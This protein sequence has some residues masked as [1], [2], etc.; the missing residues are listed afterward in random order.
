MAIQTVINLSDRQK[1]LSSL[2]LSNLRSKIVARLNIHNGVFAEIIDPPLRLEIATITQHYC[3]LLAISNT[4][5]SLRAVSRLLI[6]IHEM[7]MPVLIK[8][9]C[10]SEKSSLKKEQNRDREPL[11]SGLN[12]CGSSSPVYSSNSE[13]HC[14]A[15][16]KCLPDD[17]FATEV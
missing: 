9:F 10:F 4:Y 16:T 12:S 13:D 6:N 1:Q 11:Y 2:Y 14:G 3:S 7:N 8:I 5:W 17:L 15:N